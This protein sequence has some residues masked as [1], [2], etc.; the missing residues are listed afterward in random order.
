MKAHSNHTWNDRAD[1]LADEGA[2]ISHGVYTQWGRRKQATKDEEGT[3]QESE[4][5]TKGGVR[6][7]TCRPTE[8]LRVLRSRTRHGCLTRSATK[9]RNIPREEIGRL[10]AISIG[11]ILGERR[12]G[13]VDTSREATGAIEKVRRAGS[14]MKDTKIQRE[15]R[16]ARRR[17]MHTREIGCVVNTEPL[18]DIGDVHTW[19]PSHSFGG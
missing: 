9:Q 1:E 3:L 19:I 17:P 12:T 5:C 10:A 16:K 15:E 7:V 18:Q 11:E 4:A 2:Q 13:L 8:T 14:D 6:W